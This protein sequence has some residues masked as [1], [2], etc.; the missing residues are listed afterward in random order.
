MLCEWN[1]GPNVYESKGEFQ[2]AHNKPGW[3]ANHPPDGHTEL[4]EVKISFA[5]LGV[6]LAPGM[7]IGLALDVTNASGSVDHKW[8]F[9]PA[10]AKI[11]SPKTWGTCDCGM[12]LRT[13]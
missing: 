11:D 4:I 5:K 12:K 9:W 8:Y 2:C 1:G 3:D 6:K 10:G 13:S 7:K